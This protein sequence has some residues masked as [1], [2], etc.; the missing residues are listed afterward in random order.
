MDSPEQPRIRATAQYPQGLGSPPNSLLPDST[1]Q[2]CGLPDRPTSLLS[3]HH[4]PLA[5]LLIQSLNTPTQRNHSINSLNLNNSRNYINPR[6]TLVY[7]NTYN[8]AAL[9]HHKNTSTLFKNTRPTPWFY[10]PPQ[11]ATTRKGG[12][13]LR[14]QRAVARRLRTTVYDRFRVQY[15]I[16]APIAIATILSSLLYMSAHWW[17]LHA[18]KCP[19][20]VM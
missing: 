9:S 6:N 1:T 8:K 17:G 20:I 14:R 10:L 5:R 16:P 19:W 15:I 11:E 4:R 18:L 13:L 7:L 2:L 12:S 3:I